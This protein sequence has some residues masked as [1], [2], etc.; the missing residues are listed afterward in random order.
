VVS[1]RASRSSFVK[2]Y[3]PTH[4]GPA[5]SFFDGSAGRINCS[6][7]LLHGFRPLNHLGSGSLVGE[8]ALAAPGASMSAARHKSIT[9]VEYLE[10]EKMGPPADTVGAGNTAEIRQGTAPATSAAKLGTLTGV[11]FPCLQNIFGIL[12]FIR[13]PHLTGHAGIGMGLVIVCTCCLCTFLT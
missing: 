6:P 7:Y 4:G 8:E 5:Q 10:T 9:A 3:Q 2:A 13:L 12:L 11:L 1:T